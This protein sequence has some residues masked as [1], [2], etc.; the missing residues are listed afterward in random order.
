M[1]LIRS[2]DAGKAF[3]AELQPCDHMVD[4]YDAEGDFLASLESYVQ[5]GLA[6]GDSLVLIATRAHLGALEQRLATGGV[7]LDAARKLDKYI[8]LDA[9]ETLAKFMV[10]G[11]PD[12]ERFKAVV[13]GLLA[14]AGGNGAKVRAF[15]EMV[16]I[17]WAKKLYAATV[18]LEHLWHRLC[19]EK[20]LSLL[21]AYPVSGPTASMGRSMRE[22][23]EAHSHVITKFGL[24]PS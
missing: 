10:N 13:G 4:L 18:R 14:R 11:W 3:W 24:A 8:E 15:G 20:G 16:A 2:A 7:D 17:L 21:C 23:C 19:G 22:I 1:R 9:E 12:E 5:G 6:A